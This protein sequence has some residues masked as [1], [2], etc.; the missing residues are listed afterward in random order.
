M[1]K[2]RFIIAGYCIDGSGAGF[3]KNVYLAVSN[4]II[5]AIGNANDLTGH[6]R[7]AA[8][9]LSH[10]TIVPALVDCSVSLS[11]SP[12]MDPRLHTSRETADPEQRATLIDRH[13][14]YCHGHGVLGVADGDDPSHLVQRHKNTGTLANIITIRTSGPLCLSRDDCRGSIDIDFLKIGYA[15][16]V[17]AEKLLVPRMCHADL[18]QILRQETSKKK[19]VVAN[20]PQAV[21]EALAAGCDAIE[22]GYH[23]GEENLRKMADKGVVWIPSAIRAKNGVNSSASSG[24]V[25]CRFSQ[26][27]VAPGKPNPGAEALWQKLLASQLAQLRLART[28][29]VP[30][31]IGT[32]AGST[33]ILHGESVV[34]EIKMLIKAGYSLEEAIRCASVQGAHFFGMMELGPL[35]VGQQATF[36][37][38]RGTPYQLP[39]KLSYLEGIYINGTPSAAYQKN[40]VKVVRSCDTSG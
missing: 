15:F 6:D 36:L 27:S 8:L 28:L 21:A 26:R 25:C 32:G 12:S 5:A 30:V 16:D 24:D 3:R 18:D 23:M 17:D 2:T 34:E 38:T 37:I 14:R 39:R 19:V 29:E 11:R 1:D 31:A 35:T 40:P 7:A 9:D 4:G 10:C 20:G 33:G 13:I 22:Q